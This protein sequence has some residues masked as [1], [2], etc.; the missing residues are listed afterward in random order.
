M[1]P[2]NNV[3]LG[4]QNPVTSAKE[5]YNILLSVRCN[6]IGEVKGKRSFL[7]VDHVQTLKGGRRNRKKYLGIANDMKLQ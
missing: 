2:V 4:L 6:L 7:T 1:L 5:K 3:R